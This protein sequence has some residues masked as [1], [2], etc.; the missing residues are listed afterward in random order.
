MADVQKIE[1]QSNEQRI[2]KL[3]ADNSD[4]KIYLSDQLIAHF[5]TTNTSEIRGIIG[6]TG[7]P[8]EKLLNDYINGL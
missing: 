5:G 1:T 7:E 2:T 3:A 6:D 8:F 4:T